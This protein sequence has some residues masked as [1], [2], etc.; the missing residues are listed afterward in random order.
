MALNDCEIYP[1][2]HYRDNTEY[3]MYAY[4]KGTCPNAHRL[5]EH[6]LSLPMHIRLTYEDV[7]VVIKNILEYAK[8]QPE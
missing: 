1:G 3:S 6:I 4:G 7:Q 5:S 2:V 8:K